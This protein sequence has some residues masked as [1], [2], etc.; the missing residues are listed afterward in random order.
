MS[1]ELTVYIEMND[2]LQTRDKLAQLPSNKV[3]QVPIDVGCSSGWGNSRGK[4]LNA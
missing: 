2:E 4:L 1:D 3:I